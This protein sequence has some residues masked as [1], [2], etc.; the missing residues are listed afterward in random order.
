MRDT[1]LRDW[2]EYIDR[3]FEGERLGT[4]VNN[5]CWLCGTSLDC[6]MLCTRTEAMKLYHKSADMREQ[7]KLVRRGVEKSQ[8]VL[9][10][11]FVRATVA[12]NSSVG[13]RVFLQA[14][15]VQL[16]IFLIFF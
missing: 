6:W 5:V 7:F 2:L 11:Q 1:D 3:M 9:Q 4:P 12:R 10:M 8:Q 15:A 16:P 14:G 13:L